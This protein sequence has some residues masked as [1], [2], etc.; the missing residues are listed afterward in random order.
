MTPSRP[1]PSRPT[2]APRSTPTL[3]NALSFLLFPP[4]FLSPLMVVTSTLMALKVTVSL[5]GSP[6]PLPSPLYK[7]RLSPDL[8]LPP[9]LA[10]Q[11][12]W[13][14]RHFLPACSASAILRGCQANAPPH[15]SSLLLYRRP[16]FDP[17]RRCPRLPKPSLSVCAA[18]AARH[19]VVQH[20]VEALP[21]RR[22][23]SPCCVI[24]PIRRRPRRAATLVCVARRRPGCSPMPH[25][26]SHHRHTP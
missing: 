23:S 6:S 22:P 17:A 5:P 13:P 11:A 14:H 20:R 19:R 1:A 16:A 15:R 7:N 25:Q 12:L 9:L 8:S 4:H 21:T 18:T 24:P 2:P 3:V 26:S 10:V